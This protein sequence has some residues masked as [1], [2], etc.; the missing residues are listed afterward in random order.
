MKTR[1]EVTELIEQEYT[2]LEKTIRKNS[3]SHSLKVEE[4]AALGIRRVMIS[5]AKKKGICLEFWSTEEQAEFL[6]EKT[7]ITL[8]KNSASHGVWKYLDSL[9]SAKSLLSDILH[10]AQEYDEHETV[11]ID[12]E[13]NRSEIEDSALAKMSNIDKAKYDGFWEISRKLNACL[14]SIFHVDHAISIK[15]G[16]ESAISYKN[17]QILVKGINT[18]KNDSSWARL[19]YDAQREH[20]LSCAKVVPHSDTEYIEFLIQ[21][22]ALYWD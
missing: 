14:G 17:L 7:G 3:G 1:T 2:V 10:S 22:L 12:E 11:E 9:D 5:K 16:R 15:K 6:A 18:S 8:G 19:S 4:F 20:I 13:Y 21:Q